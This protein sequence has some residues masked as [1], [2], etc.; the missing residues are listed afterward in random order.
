MKR[1]V[2]ITALLT[3][4]VFAS[5]SALAQGYQNDPH[6]RPYFGFGIGQ[7]DVDSDTLDEID[8]GTFDIDE[9]DT[10]Y[11]LFIGYRFTPNFAVEASHLDF[12]E[13]TANAKNN[14][15][16]IELGIDGLAVALVGRL[17]LQGGFSLHGKLG[18]IAWEASYNNHFEI[19]NAQYRF[20]VEEDGTD[21][22]Y[23]VGAEYVIDRVMI[24]G[25]V[26]RYDLSYGGED[27]TIDLASISLGYHF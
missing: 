10:A 22:F 25:E 14:G 17:P 15:P 11:K 27:Y 8:D 4:T 9:S 6:A 20:Y 13:S 19:N 3:L 23:G 2:V 1:S 16:N 24:R 12:G 18:M 26:E 21:P 7:A 5:N